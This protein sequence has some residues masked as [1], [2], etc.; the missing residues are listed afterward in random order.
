MDVFFDGWCSELPDVC[1]D[2]WWCTLPGFLLSTTVIT[3]IWVVAYLACS[4]FLYPVFEPAL[5]R[6]PSKYDVEEGPYWFAWHVTS[7][8][9]AVLVIYLALVPTWQLTF[10]SPA[11]QFAPP[12]DLPQDD[13]PAFLSIARGAHIFFCYIISDIVVGS[14]YGF[15]KLDALVHHCVFLLFGLLIC[16]NC[17]G[18]YLAGWLLLMETST[19]PLNYFSY[20]RN[21]LGY[22]HW[23]V[24]AAFGC[25]AGSFMIFRLGGLLYVLMCFGRALYLQTM[26]VDGI[27]RWHLR[28]VLLA[29]TMA[30][31]M[32]VVWAASIGQKAIKVLSDD[33]SSPR[34]ATSQSKDGTYQKLKA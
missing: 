27:P 21:R 14:V 10:A 3:V 9:H 33:A 34:A 20:F 22:N 30:A 6:K 18:A 7:V 8:V 28:L 12:L 13:K 4:R 29:L 32:Q 19:V 31:G 1:D 17:F 23:S 16:Y 5:L 15:L 24:K 25:F 11:V 26:P 2:L